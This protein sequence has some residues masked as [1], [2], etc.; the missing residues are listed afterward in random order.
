MI[1]SDFVVNAYP[2]LISGLHGRNIVPEFL[3]SDEAGDQNVRATKMRKIGQQ[4]E[5]KEEREKE[6]E[7]K[8]KNPFTSFFLK[9]ALY[10]GPCLM[11]LVRLTGNCATA[12]FY[13]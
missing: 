7:R 6:K 5:T 3:H 9:Q 10:L 13:K 1:V 11:I 12:R 8:K 2:K 4:T